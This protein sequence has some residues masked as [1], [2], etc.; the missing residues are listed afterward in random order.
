MGDFDNAILT[1]HEGIEFCEK[2]EYKSKNA[3]NA[4]MTQL[5]LA[6]LFLGDQERAKTIINLL[7][8]DEL[9]RPE[10]QRVYIAYEIISGGIKKANDVLDK[11]KKLEPKDSYDRSQ[12]HL[13]LGL[14]YE[15][16][17][18]YYH[19]CIEYKNASK[20]DN[21]NVF[22][23]IKNSEANYKFGELLWRNGEDSYKG[24][25]EEAIKYTKKVLDFDPK[26]PRGIKIGS[27]LSKNF[28]ENI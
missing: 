23:L 5:G 8:D 6:Y 10:V 11:L 7:Y 3:Y 22:I 9:N 24:Y 26:S 18:D 1:F 15:G 28:N 13:L 12:H 16:I 14:F 19:A 25:I 27:L 2:I 20:Y 17:D 4:M 21:N